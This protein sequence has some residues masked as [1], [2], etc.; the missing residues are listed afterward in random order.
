MSIQLPVQISPLR[1]G[2]PIRAR[3]TSDASGGWTVIS[4]PTVAAAREFMANY[5]QAAMPCWKRSDL[6]GGVQ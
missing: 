4:F 6:F 1:P 2:Q 3:G 5:P